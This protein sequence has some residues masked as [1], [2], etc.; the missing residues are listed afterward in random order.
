M[1][2]ICGPLPCVSTMF[3]P[4]STMS[5]MERAV[6]AAALYWSGIDW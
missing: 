6:S 5:A 1:K 3:Q 2:P 4:P